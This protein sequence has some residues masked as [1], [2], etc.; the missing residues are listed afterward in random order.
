MKA[1]V[2]SR[3][4]SIHR[5]F[6]PDLDLFELHRRLAALANSHVHHDLRGMPEVER[7]AAMADVLQQIEEML[8]FEQT[9]WQ[10]ALE[11]AIRKVDE[12]STNH[13]YPAETS[14]SQ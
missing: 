3:E 2:D 11:E 1:P 12:R 7:Q 9:P 13:A 10:K 8:A 5:E 14:S 6:D 4:N